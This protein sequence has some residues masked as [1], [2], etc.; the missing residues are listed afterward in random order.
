MAVSESTEPERESGPRGLSGPAGPANAA[1]LAQYLPLS[2][3]PRRDETAVTGNWAKHLGQALIQ[4]AD[5][6][7]TI[8]DAEWTSPSARPGFSV[9][10][11]AGFV[12]WRTS[13][14]RLVRARE[15][16]SRA[17]RDRRFP[18]ATQ[19]LIGRE[20]GEAGR[21]S[22]ES[23]LRSLAVSALSGRS[24]RSVADLAVVVLACYDIGSVAGEPIV[25]D[26]VASGAVALARSLSAPVEIRAVLAS[27]ALVSSDGDWRVGKGQERSGTSSD[28]VLF[29]YGRAP[30][31]PALPSAS[32]PL[33]E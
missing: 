16:A 17:L 6:L 3:R 4:L 18:P 28:I 29:L 32:T 2:Q 11:V 31:P 33:V 24:S 5:A 21:V 9:A 26:P 19:L 20:R 23:E 27:T 7:G 15:R 12:V 10:D 25:I 14:P 1:E 13:T 22:V 30:L 8:T